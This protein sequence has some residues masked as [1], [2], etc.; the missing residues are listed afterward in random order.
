MNSVAGEVTWASV[1][2]IAVFSG[3][4]AGKSQMLSVNTLYMTSVHGYMGQPVVTA[5]S[6]VASNLLTVKP[7]RL[8]EPG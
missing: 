4:Y 3:L 7:A 1:C 2:L 6:Q 8:S 5:F